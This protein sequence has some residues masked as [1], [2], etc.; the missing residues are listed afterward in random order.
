MS[1][2]FRRMKDLLPNDMA[3]APQHLKYLATAILC[4]HITA[5]LMWR[6]TGEDIIAEMQFEGHSR[7]QIESVLNYVRCNSSLIKDYLDGTIS[8]EVNAAGIVDGLIRPE[9]MKIDKVI[10]LPTHHR[11]TQHIPHRKDIEVRIDVGTAATV[12]VGSVLHLGAA[13]AQVVELHRFYCFEA[14]LDAYDRRLLPDARTPAAALRQYQSLKSY[15]RL[16]RVSLRTCSVHARS[17]R[18]TSRTETSARPG[19]ILGECP[20][21]APMPRCDSRAGARRGSG[22]SLGKAQDPGH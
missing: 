16:V 6:V 10:R 7:Y 2:P 13:V 18:C 5:R 9:P 12:Q 22:D 14:I 20:G 21:G 3:K 15:K 4:D 1:I 11:F 17:H 8:L 19:K